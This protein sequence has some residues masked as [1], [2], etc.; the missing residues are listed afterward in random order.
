LNDKVLT[1]KIENHSLAFVYFFSRKFD[2]GANKS[3]IDEEL[4]KNCKRIP[5]PFDFRHPNFVQIPKKNSVRI[6][7]AD[8]FG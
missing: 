1:R 3:G 4:L 7:E 8:N 6:L 2:S 5:Q